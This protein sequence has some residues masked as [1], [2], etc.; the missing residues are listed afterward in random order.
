MRPCRQVVGTRRVVLLGAPPLKAAAGV[1]QHRWL[2]GHRGRL[3]EWLCNPS[4]GCCIS[5]CRQGAHAVAHVRLA[6]CETRGRPGTCTEGLVTRYS[7]RLPKCG[8]HTMCDARAQG[9][10]RR[11]CGGRGQEPAQK[12]S[13]ICP[14][15]GPGVTKLYEIRKLTPN[16]SARR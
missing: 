10:A 12:A 2:H 15:N 3:A 6:G 1:L 13:G 7:T 8:C 9:D 11:K 14:G 5:N 16:L 4:T